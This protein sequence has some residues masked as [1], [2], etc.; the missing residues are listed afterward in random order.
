MIVKI[1][2][3]VSECDDS[4]EDSGGGDVMMMVDDDDE[5][6]IVDDIDDDDD[7]GGGDDNDDSVSLGDAD[8]IYLLQGVVN[9]MIS[10]FIPV[11]NKFIFSE[12]QFTTEVGRWICM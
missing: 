12:K 10:L 4:D 6:Y 1:V 8:G 2:K 3:I 7:D 9:M 11:K 5:D